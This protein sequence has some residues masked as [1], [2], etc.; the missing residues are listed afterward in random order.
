MT[1]LSAIAEGFDENCFV[2]D[3]IKEELEN[4]PKFERGSSPTPTGT[5]EKQKV[6]DELAM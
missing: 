3:S 5:P 1:S 4:L 6:G 2:L